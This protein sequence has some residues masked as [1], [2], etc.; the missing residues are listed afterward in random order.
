MAENQQAM[1]PGVEDD[2]AQLSVLS[3]VLRAIDDIKDSCNMGVS[4]S[5]FPTVL[6]D[7][8][9][10]IESI[11][12][13]SLPLNLAAVQSL[14]ALSQSDYQAEDR[15]TFHYIISRNFWHIEKRRISFA[16]AWDDVLIEAVNKA[17]DGLGF[18]PYVR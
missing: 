5:L 14:L 2:D 9:L 13:I 11:G 12:P 4:G 1:S 16:S 18:S 10:S 6:I 17:R 8:G 15:P 7:I 3:K